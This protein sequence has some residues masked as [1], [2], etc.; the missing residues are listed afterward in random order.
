MSTAQ[1]IAPGQSVSDL[2]GGTQI[3]SPGGPKQLGKSGSA[4]WASVVQRVLG[5]QSPSTQKVGGPL[6]PMGSQSGWSTHSAQPPM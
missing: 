1:R 5:S 4:H 2:H 3:R 6:V